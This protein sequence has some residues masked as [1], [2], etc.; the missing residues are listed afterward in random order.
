MTDD[1]LKELWNIKDI[2]AK[3]HGNSIDGLA[4]YYLQKQTKYPSKI[5]LTKK[6]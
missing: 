1:L 5:N 2:I 3:E 4:E 6:L